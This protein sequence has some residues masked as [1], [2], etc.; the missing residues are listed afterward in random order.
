ME[1][2]VALRRH[3]DR[4]AAAIDPAKVIIVGDTPHD[5]SCAQRGGARAV[6]VATG[7]F[8]VPTLGRWQPDLVC[9]EDSQGTARCHAWC[10]DDN[11]CGGASCVSYGAAGTIEVKLCAQ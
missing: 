9:A 7:N 6:A 1:F 2:S 11:D 8:D 4:H 10:C 3:H 5:V